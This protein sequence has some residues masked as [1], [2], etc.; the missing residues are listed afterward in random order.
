MRGGSYF[1]NILPWKGCPVARVISLSP[2]LLFALLCPVRHRVA[3]AD[4]TAES[5]HQVL[6]AG[7]AKRELSAAFSFPAVCTWRPGPL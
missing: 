7:R 5:K 4:R 3:V 6:G 1:N 2:E